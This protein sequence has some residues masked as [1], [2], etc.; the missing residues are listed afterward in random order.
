METTSSEEIGLRKDQSV[1]SNLQYGIVSEGFMAKYGFCLRL[2]KQ[3]EIAI[4]E[5]NCLL[6]SFSK[7]FQWP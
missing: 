7:V 1:Q 2:I 6:S 4:P 3:I 5:K